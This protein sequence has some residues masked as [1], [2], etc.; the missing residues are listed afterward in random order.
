MSILNIAATGMLAQEKNV[1]VISNNIANMNTAGYKVQRTS[2]HDLTYKTELRA[3]T[4]S[5]DAGTILPTGIQVGSG[6]KVASV[7][8]IFSQ[9]GVNQTKGTLDMM[10]DGKGYFQ[11][12]LPNGETAYT[13]DGAFKRSADGTLVTLRGYQVQPGITIPDAE[14]ITV[15][16]SGEVYATVAGQNQPVNL[17]QLQL[18]RFVNDAGL[19]A[20]GGNLFQESPASGAPQTDV[21]GANGFGKIMQGQLETSNVNVVSEI[22]TLIKAQR[23]YEMNSRVINIGDEMM[24][25]S[26]SIV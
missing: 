10:I 14:K 7:Y 18:A 13:R 22:T 2:F 4:A 12:T 24:R 8:R 11:V 20:L 6:A 17:G 15:N 3:G 26:T 1:D 16:E 21:P 19:E 23:A 9:G 25:A 5:S